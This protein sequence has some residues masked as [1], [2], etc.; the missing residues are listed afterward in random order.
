MSKNRVSN[1]VI[2]SSKDSILHSEFKMQ[3]IQNAQDNFV[4]KKWT[5]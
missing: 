5:F 3:K 4:S 2:I 1:Q